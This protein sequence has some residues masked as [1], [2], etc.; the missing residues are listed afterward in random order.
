[1]PL[2][3][4][5]LCHV[6]NCAHWFP[7]TAATPFCFLHFRS[8]ELYAMKLCHWYVTTEGSGVNKVWSRV[9][10]TTLEQCSWH[11]QHHVLPCWLPLHTEEWGVVTVNSPDT[12]MRRAVK[13][14]TAPFITA[15]GAQQG[16]KYQRFPHT[17]CS[18]NRFQHT[19]SLP[20]TI[21]L[22]HVPFCL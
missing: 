16:H 9:R 2:D 19:F 10:I 6:H 11:R 21:I 17:P 8:L 1:M 20:L 4:K 18:T 15:P 5:S 12:G 7:S 14:Y 13:C 3:I 22:P